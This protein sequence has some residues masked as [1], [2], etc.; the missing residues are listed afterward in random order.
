[1]TTV[2]KMPPAPVKLGERRKVYDHVVE[3]IDV[4]GQRVYCRYIEGPREGKTTWVGT[5]AFR[6]MEKVS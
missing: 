6:K 3:V 1:M 4:Q 5:T 2:K